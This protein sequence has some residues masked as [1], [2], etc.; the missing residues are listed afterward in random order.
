MS[1]RR[2]LTL[3]YYTQIH[4]AV[5]AFI[6]ASSISAVLY[7]HINWPVS[8]LVGLSTF[9]IYSLDN[10]F[11]WKKDQ[12]HYQEII[13]S[14]RKYHKIT[15]FLIPLSGLGVIL[16]A[17]NSPNE[18]KIGILLL[19]AGAGMFT[20][21]FANYRKISSNNNKPF[22]FF[23]INR[24][25]ISIVWTI[26]VV[27]L[28]IWYEGRTI[29]TLTWHTFI[30][31]FNLVLVYAIIWKFEKTDSELKKVIVQRC[32]FQFLTFPL[33]ISTSVVIYD[34]AIGLRTMLSLFNLPPIAISIFYIY[35][36][37]TK[38]YQLRQK[39]SRFSILI[40]LTIAI[41]VL[42]HLLLV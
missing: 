33:L 35:K 30:F 39:I 13:I 41:S 8:L 24:I 12:A 28:P 15:F 17:L 4:L 38:P 26:V 3:L 7:E 37:S 27:F 29:S 14:I 18:L 40:I 36:I 6:L 9:L 32:I 31:I 11:D 16:L 34:I 20:A 23:I 10:L 42:F 25:F 19:G 1:I 2:K 5:L 21:R 22:A